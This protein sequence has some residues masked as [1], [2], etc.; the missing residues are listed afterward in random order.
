[1][2][3]TDLSGLYAK[4]IKEAVESIERSLS[5]FCAMAGFDAWSWKH[6]DVTMH[7]MNMIRKELGLEEVQEDY[8]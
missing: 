5:L 3:K 1:M 2:N 8:K 4:D 6:N 7:D